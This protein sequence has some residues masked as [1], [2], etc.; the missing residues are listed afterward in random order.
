MRSKGFKKSRDFSF[1]NP[2]ILADCKSRDP[3]I[4]G[5]PLGPGP[6]KQLKNSKIPFLFAP[7]NSFSIQSII[8]LVFF[9]SSSELITLLQVEVSHHLGNPLL[10]VQRVQNLFK[11]Q[12]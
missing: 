12:H 9:S 10:G 4:P 11:W 8:I 2:G 6:L 5:I 1:E 3:G 7:N